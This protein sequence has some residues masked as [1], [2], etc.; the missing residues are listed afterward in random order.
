MVADFERIFFSRKQP[1]K[2]LSQF[3]W[4]KQNFLAACKNLRFQ[5]QKFNFV[6]Q[7]NCEWSR[8][9]A[10]GSSLGSFS[11][12][13]GFTRKCFQMWSDACGPQS[14]LVFIIFK[15]F[16]NSQTNFY[17]DFMTQFFC[18]KIELLGNI[19][20]E[21]SGVINRQKKTTFQA[22]LQKRYPL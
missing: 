15:K 6:E 16:I 17:F 2:N 7:Q 12:N 21:L 14:R 3:E 22:S 9:E 5:K 10:G 1:E 13:L 4:P 19:A 20:H 11:S 8:S 18:S